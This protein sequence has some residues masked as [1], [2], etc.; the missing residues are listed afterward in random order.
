M[1]RAEMPGSGR[2]SGLYRQETEEGGGV[3]ENILPG[4]RWL[5]P[6]EKQPQ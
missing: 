1:S 6:K 4:F 2:G 5:D 3:R